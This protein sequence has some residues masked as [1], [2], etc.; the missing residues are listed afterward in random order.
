MTQSMQP[1]SAPVDQSDPI[2]R[3]AEAVTRHVG[4]DPLVIVVQPDGD[5]PRV[6]ANDANADLRAAVMVT[7][8][9]DNDRIWRSIATRSQDR[10]DGTV[11]QPIAAMPEVVRAAAEANFLREVYVAIGP[12]GAPSTDTPL[13]YVA[14]WFSEAGVNDAAT[15]AARRQTIQLLDAALTS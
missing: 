13:Q 10:A 1:S 15:V 5:A 2:D 3:V 8:A 9:V 14:V 4:G 11:S 12:V 6:H 7:V